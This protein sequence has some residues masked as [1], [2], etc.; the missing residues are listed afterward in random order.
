VH[1][2]GTTPPGISAATPQVALL[3]HNQETS[4]IVF[5]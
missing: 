4:E 2:L 3:Q 1:N 5:V